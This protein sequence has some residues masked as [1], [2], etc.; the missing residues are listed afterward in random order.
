MSK[1]ELL[2]LDMFEKGKFAPHSRNLLRRCANVEEISLVIDLR[3][4]A[5]TFHNG[6]R[7]LD[8]D[9][10]RSR[11]DFASL[12]TMAYL[13]TVTLAL[14]PFMALETQLRR[15]VQGDQAGIETP[16]EAPGVERFWGLKDWL[17][18]NGPPTL[19]VRCPSVKQ[20]LGCRQ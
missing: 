17:L 3:D 9:A 20:I 5:F 1:L 15:M 4:L 10:L 16:D 18:A 12:T 2:G 11:Y 13:R 6:I 8:M 7:Y 19:V 14:K